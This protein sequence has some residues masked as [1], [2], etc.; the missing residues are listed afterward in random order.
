MGVDRESFESLRTFWRAPTLASR[1]VGVLDVPFAPSPVPLAGFEIA[2]WGTHDGVL[3]SMRAWPRSLGS[4][5]RAVAGR[6]PATGPLD[7]AAWGWVPADFLDRCIDGVRRRGR[8]IEHLLQEESPELFIA[9]FGE[10]HTASH[11]LWH[12]APDADRPDTSALS[13]ERGLVDLFREVDRQI[14]RALTAA[15]DEA[16][17]LVFSLYGMRD[18]RG[19]PSFLDALLCTVGLAARGSGPE[20]AALRRGL[21]VGLKRA[22]QRFVPTKVKVDLAKFGLMPRYDWSRTRAFPLPTDQHGWI[23]VNLEGR[24]AEGIV[25][26]SEYDRVC[27]EIERLLSDLRMED[28]TAVVR[29]VVRTSPNYPAG[30]AGRLPDLVVHWAPAATR[31]P[32]RLRIPPI[33]SELAAS[34]ITAEHSPEGFWVFRSPRA[35]GPSNGTSIPV[36]ALGGLLIDQLVTR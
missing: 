14:E 32:F 1:R 31:E 2:E 24:E 26:R 19:L 30:V 18:S 28:G 29:D 5:V 34:R 16:A 36:Q 3:G 25:E 22:Y 33:R 13:N 20:L 23:R 27:G 21:P 15:G 10:T 12:T 4:R 6:H 7:A 17:V 35:G 11:L 9:V 8:L